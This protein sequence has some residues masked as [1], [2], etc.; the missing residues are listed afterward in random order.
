LC[1]YESQQD[2]RRVLRKQQ[3]LRE[4]GLPFSGGIRCYGWQ[5]DRLTLIPDEAEEIRHMADMVLS[6][7]SLST[8]VKDLNRRGVRTVSQ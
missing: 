1:A 5:A 3:E 8:V 2:S 6:G 7:N 4:A